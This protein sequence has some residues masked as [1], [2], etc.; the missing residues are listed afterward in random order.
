MTTQLGLPFSY[1]ESKGLETK[2]CN[3]SY[4]PVIKSHL[5]YHHV[6]NTSSCPFVNVFV[7]LVHTDKI[8]PV[9]E[10]CTFLL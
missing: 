1:V 7:S 9:G 10:I 8:L 4:L 6:Y 3:P 5:L 2:D